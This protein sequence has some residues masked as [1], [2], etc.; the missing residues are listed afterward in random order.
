MAREAARAEATAAGARAYPANRIIRSRCV[1]RHMCCRASSMISMHKIANSSHDR[2]QSL[3][4]GTVGPRDQ[5]SPVARSRHVDGSVSSGSVRTRGPRPPIARSR[6][7]LRSFKPCWTRSFHGVGCVAHNP[8][9][10][11]LFIVPSPTVLS[12]LAEAIAASNEESTACCS[13]LS[14][15][16]TARAKLRARISG[17]FAGEASLRTHARSDDASAALHRDQ[18]RSE[19]TCHFEAFLSYES[20]DS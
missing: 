11:S 4:T 17:I 12:S 1:R 8:R 9:G 5:S 13:C 15:C 18:R 3:F 20:V 19:V 16:A 2:S 10:T 6:P 14:R 7:V